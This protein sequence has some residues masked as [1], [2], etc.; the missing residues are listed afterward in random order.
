MSLLSFIEKV[1]QLAS[2]KEAFF[3][4]IDFEKKKPMVFSPQEANEKGIYFAVNGHTNYAAVTQPNLASKVKIHPVNFERYKTAF[5]KVQC[6]LSQGDSYLVNLTFPSKIKLDRDLESFFHA[7]KAPYRLLIKNT[8]LSYSPEC[9]IKIRNGQLF[10]YPMKGTIDANSP[11][12]E[13]VLLG[14]PKELWEHSTIVDL[15]RNDISQF[16]RNVKVNKFRYIDKIQNKAKD[17]LQVSSE[18]EGRLPANW[19]NH[20]GE[21]IWDLLPAGS[22][23]GAPKTKTIEIIQSVEARKRG[24]YTGVY[25]YFDGENLDSAV[26]IRYI[27]QQDNDFYYWSGGGITAYSSLEEEYQ[28]LKDKIYV[29]T[30]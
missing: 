14:N 22:I 20:L 27:E 24:Y 25:G 1:N 7:A 17:L 8:L 6:H 30:G 18:I 3:F 2:R 4:L 26:A 11:N 21:I 10:S 13:E 23:S 29:P 12:A 16:A 28:E 19:K 5:D 9:F 15:I